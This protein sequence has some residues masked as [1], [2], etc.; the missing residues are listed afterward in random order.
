MEITSTALA[1]STSRYFEVYRDGVFISR[2]TV[3]EEAYESCATQGAGTYEVRAPGKLVVID[4]VSD[5]GPDPDPVPDPPPPPPPDPDPVP[6]P[7]PDPE[8]GAYPYFDSLVA[9]P[10]HYTSAHLRT[11]TNV[12]DNVYFS[13]KERATTYYDLEHDAARFIHQAG[14]GSIVGG[15]QVR[16]R[17]PA[18]SD[19]TLFIVWQSKMDATWSNTGGLETQKAFQISR[20]GQLSFEPRHRYVQAVGDSIARLDVRTYIGASD[21]GPADSVG[22]DIGDFYVYPDVWT[23]YAMFMDISNNEAS[24]WA[25]DENQSPVQILDREGVP[26][27][28]QGWSEFWFEY[29]SSQSRSGQPEAYAWGRNLAILRDLTLSEAQ[30][31]IP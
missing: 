20:G 12:I 21:P 5:P 19:G 30:S 31:L 29:N 24:Y 8:P 18:V 16:H 10:N 1:P 9:N 3:Q 17:F 15:D 4:A 26:F 11:Q 27:S 23:T 22:S 2:H 6:D 13:R 28:G 14:W 7:E 25:W